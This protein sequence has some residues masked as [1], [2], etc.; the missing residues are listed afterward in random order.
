MALQITGNFSKKVGGTES[1]AAVQS[2]IA[3]KR[4]LGLRVGW[5]FGGGHFLAIYGWLVGAS[6][7][8]YYL[9]A[10]PIYG[11]SQVAETALQSSYQGTGSWSHSYH[12][13]PP[14][15]AGAAVARAVAAVDPTSIG[16]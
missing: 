16:A 1:F 9:V 4:P 11:S 3:S 15:A 13:A 10:D 12:C 8:R 14:V 7:A 6:G 2:V 5:Q